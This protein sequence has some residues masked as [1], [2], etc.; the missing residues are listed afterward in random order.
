M[1]ALLGMLTGIGGGMARDLFL[2][3]IP[4]VLRTDFYATAALL[5]AALVV[6]GHLMH[7]PPLIV[8]LIATTGCFGIRLAAIYCG[9]RLPIGRGS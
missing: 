1:A 9:W 7:F 3:Q 4:S 2:A 5:G 8:A 6:I